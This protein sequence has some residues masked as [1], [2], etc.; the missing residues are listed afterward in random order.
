VLGYNFPRQATLCSITLQ[1]EELKWG[2][3]DA[4]AYTQ[5]WEVGTAAYAP[6][7]CQTRLLIRLCGWLPIAARLLA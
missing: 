3:F 5:P 2:L 6:C 7:T 4:K 1:A